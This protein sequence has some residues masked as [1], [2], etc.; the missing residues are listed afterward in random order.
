MYGIELMI[1]IG[2]TLALTLS[3]PGPALSIVGVMI[4]W[5]V[6]LG[7]G[8]GGDYPLSSIITSEFATVKWRG[9]MMAAVFAN[10]GFGSFTAALVS[11]ICTVASKDSLQVT[12]CDADCQ[13]ALDKSWRVIYGFG[14][15]PAVCALYFRL[16]IP[17]TIR[18]TLDVDG[19]N[20]RARADAIKY[21]SGRY[22]SA[23]PGDE[24]YSAPMQEP[25]HARELKKAS[26]RDFY[27]HFGQWK[28]GKVLLG[29]ASSWFLLDVGFVRHS[30]CYLT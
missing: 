28:H 18:Y 22:G 2:A 16:T 27:D 12:T 13:V 5:R 19:N 1:I 9:A 6:I 26:F 4:L 25:D 15:I 14:A 24:G 17:E 30:V 3:A 29:T 11:F 10:Q 7:V 20:Q 21:V 23:R 8:I